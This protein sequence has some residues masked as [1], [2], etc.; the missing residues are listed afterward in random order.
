MHERDQLHIAS[1]MLWVRES[2]ADASIGCSSVC[3]Q[4]PLATCITRRAGIEG[5]P[6]GAPSPI[7]GGPLGPRGAVPPSSP[8][9]GSPP[10]SLHVSLV[11][12]ASTV[13]AFMRH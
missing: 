12:S 4:L 3:H 8:D 9:M 1:R 6:R 2:P 11:D 13:S 7:A 5:D 10:Q